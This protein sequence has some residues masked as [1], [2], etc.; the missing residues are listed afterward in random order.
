MSNSRQ[1]V[2]CCY[3]GTST[4]YNER[5]IRKTDRDPELVAFRNIVA[6]LKCIDLHHHT[7]IS[8]E[9]ISDHHKNR[10]LSI[11]GMISN[12]ADNDGRGAQAKRIPTLDPN[13]P[14]WAISIPIIWSD[15]QATG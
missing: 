11:D 9:Y 8:I 1:L 15:L 6:S 2:K 14:T 13:P 12:V 7:G 3:K 10:S 4:A 5:P